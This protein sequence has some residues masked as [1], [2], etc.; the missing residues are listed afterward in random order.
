[1]DTEIQSIFGRALGEEVPAE[2][3]PAAESPEKDAAAL[4]AAETAAREEAV[5]AYALD[6]AAARSGAQDPELLKLLLEREGL[7]VQ[8]GTVQGLEAAVAA[9]RR[10]RPYLFRDGGGR[11]R[12]SAATMD[13]GLSTEEETVAQRYRNNPWY[14]KKSGR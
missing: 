13:R 14:R 9:I 4:Q 8:D 11:P 6:A 2:G 5:L 1:M 12:F 3:A 7:T 10:Q